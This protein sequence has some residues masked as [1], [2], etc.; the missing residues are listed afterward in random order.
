MLIK[1]LAWAGALVG[2]FTTQSAI[3]DTDY[4]GYEM[5]P[6]K[7][8]QTLN[9]AEIRQYG[10]HLLAEVRVSGSRPQA[11]NKGFRVLAN[12]I[13]GGNAEGEKIAMTV[14]V[15]Q[16]KDGDVWTV[17][18]MMP[19][20]FT[21]ATLPT[22]QTDAIKFIDKPGDTQIVRQFSGRVGAKLPEQT[23]SLKK[24]AAASGKAVTGSPKYYFYDDPFT[25]PWKRR[26]EVAFS[27][28]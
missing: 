8:V 26:N 5:P 22:A 16:T 10:P 20:K 14:P 24:I 23:A 17:S 18:F 15:A 4:R 6:Y 2:A 12:Y 9:G 11:A 7:V 19:S 3:A 27:I 13:F 1:Q 25:A 21:R 28:K